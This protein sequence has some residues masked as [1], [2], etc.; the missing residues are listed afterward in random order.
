MGLALFPIAQLYR[1]EEDARPLGADDRLQ[2]RQL[3]S[4]PIPDKL[5]NYLEE[6]QQS[7]YLWEF[8]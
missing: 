8:S 6:T 7:Q 5:R 3:Q 1:V 2:L 4:R